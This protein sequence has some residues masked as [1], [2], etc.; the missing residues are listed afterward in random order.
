MLEANFKKLGILLSVF[1]LIA[2]IVM[3]FGKQSIIEALN[4]NSDQFK[5]MVMTPVL[6]LIIGLVVV[7][8]S[9]EKIEDE[10]VLRYR[11]NAF[12]YSFKMGLGYVLGKFILI[13][14]GIGSIEKL[15]ALEVIFVQI[16]IYLTLFHRSLKNDKTC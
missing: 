3:I 5:L 10:R 4:I 14:F 8:L 6:L 2:F 9:K 7:V 1:S 11:L 12:Q 15:N 16:A 13:Y